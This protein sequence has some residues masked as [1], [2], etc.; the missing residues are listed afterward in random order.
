MEV[1]MS[2]L[3]YILLICTIGMSSCLGDYPQYIEWITIEGGSFMM[4]SNS[5][6]GDERPVHMV[7]VPSFQIMKTE[8]TVGMY[9]ACI[10]AGRCNDSVS[11]GEDHPIT[12]V[13]WHQ[14]M[15]FAA[16][17]GA[18]LPTEAEWEFAATNR[19][20]STY[21][22]GDDAPDCS[23]AQYDNCSGETTVPVCSKT[24]G[25]TE[26]GLCDMAGNV[27]EWVQD[28]YHSNYDGAPHD[29]SGWCNGVCPENASDSNYNASD[30]A[31]RVFRGGGWTNGSSG[32]RS[33]SRHYNAPSTQYYSYGGRLARSI[34]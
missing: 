30:S 7:T 29:G 33:A 11:G 4:G 32:M 9:Q 19:G 12:G 13:D 6:D 28:E 1:V 17:V 14:M 24:A 22:W 8:V 21:P 18:R 34:P 5:G 15:A 27:W 3:L 25:L 31:D 26:Q 23:R 16:W 10:D 2:R 20:Q